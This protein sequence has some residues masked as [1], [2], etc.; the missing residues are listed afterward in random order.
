[1]RGTDDPIRA[2]ADVL[3]EPV[4]AA[5]SRLTFTG[6]GIDEVLVP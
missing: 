1:V 2:A 3:V 6:H 5:R 4:T